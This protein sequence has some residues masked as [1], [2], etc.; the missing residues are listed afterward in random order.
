VTNPPQCSLG[1]MRSSNDAPIWLDAH[2]R[3]Q[4][5]RACWTCGREVVLMRFPDWCGLHNGVS[6]CRRPRLVAPRAGLGPGP[7]S[8]V[9]ATPQASARPARRAGHRDAAGPQ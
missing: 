1:R 4:P 7:D 2:G 6:R 9:I 5:T 8:C 3:Q